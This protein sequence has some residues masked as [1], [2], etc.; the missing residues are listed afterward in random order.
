PIFNI[1]ATIALSIFVHE[2]GDKHLVK[3]T[4]VKIIKNP[5]IIG[6]MLGIVALLI[7]LLFE[8]TNVSFRLTDIAFLYSSLSMISRTSTPVALITLGG[9][10]NLRKVKDNILTVSIVSFVRL[11]LIPFLVFLVCLTM[12]DFGA[13]E[14]ATLIGVFGS[15]VAVSSAIMAKEMG[16]DDELANEIVVVTTIFSVVTIFLAIYIFRVMGVF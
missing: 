16:S 11:A 13:A 2:E 6:I 5:L 9:L 8:K 7:R 14:Y 1:L 15:P 3:S 4:I 12:F 10:F